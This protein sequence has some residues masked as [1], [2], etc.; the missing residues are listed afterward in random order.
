MI[1]KTTSKIYY[2]SFD[3]KVIIAIRTSRSRSAE[4]KDRPWGYKVRDFVAEHGTGKVRFREQDLFKKN[5]RGWGARDGT[6]LTIFFTGSDLVDKLKKEFGQHVR[7]IEKPLSDAH[8]DMLTK[9]RV[10]TRKSLFHRKYRY[11]VRVEALSNYRTGWRRD[12]DKLEE[13]KKW[14][15]ETF[16]HLEKG[17]DYHTYNGWYKANFF[18]KNAS[19]AILMKMTWGDEILSTERI[20]LLEEI[21]PSE[22]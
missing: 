22:E 4:Y 10:I 5:K 14:H 3:H 12:T 17:S 15:T 19:D 16:A 8:S 21:E 6:G 20:R 9:E 7:F 13:I 2:G 18:F 11:C 1:E